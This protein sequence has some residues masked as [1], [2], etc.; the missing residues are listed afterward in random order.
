MIFVYPSHSEY[1]PFKSS[2]KGTSDTIP[3]RNLRYKGTSF[4]IDQRSKAYPEKYDVEIPVKRTPIPITCQSNIKYP[5]HTTPNLP[6]NQADPLNTSSHLQ[7]SPQDPHNTTQH[8]HTTTP[9]PP[10]HDVNLELPHPPSLPP[11]LPP[12]HPPNNPH[13]H[14]PPRLPP[15]R[16][17]SPL[18]R[19]RRPRKSNH[20]KLDIHPNHHIHHFPPPRR[21]PTLRPRNHGNRPQHKIHRP[22]RPH[23]HHPQRHRPPR[24]PLHHVHHT[25]NRPRPRLPLPI[26]Q[27]LDLT[28]RHLHSR[29]HTAGHILGS[30]ARH[31][32]SHHTPHFSEKK[33]SHFPHAA[34]CEFAGLVASSWKEPI[35]RKVDEYVDADLP[36]EIEWWDEGDF[37][38]NGMEDMMPDREAM[39]M[40]GEEKF[41]VVRI[42]GAGTYPC[43]GTHVNSTRECGKTSVKKITR[44]KGTS[45]VGY[46]LD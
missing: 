24:R 1:Y 13:I 19:S 16:R 31:L 3:Q 36:V 11:R 25:P 20:P 38:A 30:A 17:P 21:R 9:Q 40:T 45:R 7:P 2:T 41:R 33:A 37:A 4:A 6:P 29:Y 27:T 22:T 28:T 12:L 44:S 35:Q 14:N 43:G 15:P 8:H 5:A 23:Q 46:T 34:A 18:Q 10:N 39:G 32:L 42:V 26:T